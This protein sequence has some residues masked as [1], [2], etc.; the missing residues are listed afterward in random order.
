MPLPLQLMLRKNFVR[1]PTP[2][3]KDTNALHSC[4]FDAFAP[5]KPDLSAGEISILH[6]CFPHIFVAKYFLDII[7]ATPPIAMN[8]RGTNE[9]A[10][11]LGA[12]PFNRCRT[13]ARQIEEEQQSGAHSHP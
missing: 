10:T 6:K 9:S 2:N 8:E 3:K 1:Q 7:I 12:S 11:I 4:I 5:P 13:R